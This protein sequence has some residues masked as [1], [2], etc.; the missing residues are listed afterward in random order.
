MRRLATHQQVRCCPNNKKVVPLNTSVRTQIGMLV[1]ATSIV[2]LANGFFGTFISL[3]VAV[4]GFDFPGLVLSA[5]FAGFTLGAMIGIK[6]IE[7]VGH[8]RAYAAFAGL[9]AVA[10]SLMPLLVGSPSW[11]ILRAIVGFGCAGVFVATESWLTA[12]AEPSQR[13]KVFSIYMVGT[14]LAL[15]LGQLFIAR[16]DIKASASFNVVVTFFAVA[17]VMVAGTRADPPRVSTVPALP[18]GVLARTAPIAVVGCALSGLVGGTFYSLVPA[19]M[20]GQETSRQT[21]ALFMLAVVLGGLAFQIPVGRLSD[22][23]D[24]RIVLASLSGGFAV[25][26]FVMVLMPRT[27]VIILP[28]AVLLGGFMSTLYPDCVAH[29][30]DRMPADRVLAVSGRLILVSGVGS[31]LGPLIGASAMK[32]FKIDG[33]FYFMAATVLLLALVAICESLM[34]PS[35]EHIATPFDILTPQ[36][37]PLA[38][39][40]K[41]P[42]DELSQPTDPR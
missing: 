6:I 13:G 20:Q 26:A 28:L 22:R 31:V 41:E 5:Y 30:H 1:V 10:A 16:A 32:H 12:K 3:R 14:F 38:H 35:P 23:F 39:D 27:V 33:V 34:R 7:R 2:Q 37:G 42:P 17:L 15:A 40:P 19:W 24:R 8:I 11:V 9:V 29:A 18:Y 21:I 4:E 25:S 36:A